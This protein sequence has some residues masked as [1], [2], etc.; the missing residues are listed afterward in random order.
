MDRPTPGL[1]RVEYFR[2]IWPLDGFPWLLTG[3]TTW[4]I[5]P[6]LQ[7]ADLAGA[8]G[9][10]FLTALAAGVGVD[11]A[12]RYLSDSEDP[13]PRPLT[14]TVVAGALI[15]GALIYG[16]VR[17]GTLRVGPGPLV[18][19]VQGNIPQELKNNI[20]MAHDIYDRYVATT[21]MLNEDEAGRF[22]DLVIWPETVFPYP[23]G[24]GREEDVWTRDGYGYALS[25]IAEQRY[26]KQAVIDRYLASR[27]TWFLTG[28]LSYRRNI[29][30]ELEKR[31]GAYLYDP[32]GNRRDA[33][34]KTLL[35]P[36]GEYLPW[37]DYVP[38]GSGIKDLVRGG[39]GF[40]PDLVPGHGPEPMMISRKGRDF[41]F[42][43][44]I[45]FENI[46]GD[47]CRRF[48]KKG[49][50]FVVNLSNEGWFNTSAEFDQMLAMSLFRAVETRRSLFRSTN[51]G[52]SCLIGPD[53]ALPGPDARIQVD[54]RD[55]A[56]QGVLVREVP[57]CGNDTVYTAVG[58]LFAQIVMGGQIIFTIFL[59]FT[60]RKD[61]KSSSGRRPG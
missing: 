25:L 58:D 50:H 23:L 32:K 2:S 27:E 45:C 18:A 22:P 10:T 3:Y 57:I 41:A 1:D 12:A 28:L 47:Y 13:P 54:G 4:K 15:A 5:S 38:F 40:L 44:Q 43:V 53:G 37:I 8:Y 59:L 52:I 35:V 36:G 48:A 14:G 6:L 55:R 20:S 19:A 34:Y 51:T 33:Y 26:I 42:G 30:N 61:T 46:Y 39:A 17:P 49:A 21:G 9:L 29:R 24:D 31:N 56:V 60:R 16:W 11:W 7:C